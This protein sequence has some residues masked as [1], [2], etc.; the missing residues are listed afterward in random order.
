[1]IYMKVVIIQIFQN[2][3]VFENIY[4]TIVYL[5]CFM[6]KIC[7]HIEADG[8]NCTQPIKQNQN[9]CK[10]HTCKCGKGK[11]SFKERCIVCEKNN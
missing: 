2:S 6:Y 10:K 7:K 4:Y 5:F 11:P 1:M 9:H 8:L 3:K